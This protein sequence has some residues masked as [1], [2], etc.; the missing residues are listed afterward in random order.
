M[1]LIRIS[2][3]VACLSGLASGP[4]S[5]RAAG[6]SEPNPRTHGEVN[7]ALDAVKRQGGK[8]ASPSVDGGLIAFVGRDGAGDVA[9]VWLINLGGGAPRRLLGSLP[10]DDPKANLTELT[11][12]K[13][14]NDGRTVYVQSAAW[15]TSG[16]VH[17]IDVA[18]GAHRF[19]AA[20]NSLAVV[21]N[22][23]YSGSLIVSQHMYRRSGG[24][25]EQLWLLR[26]DGR[27]RFAIPGSSADP[28][29]PSDW[30]QRNGWRAQ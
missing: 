7:G 16:A 17:A 25:F 29:D 11:G 4:A 21:R 24:S 8:D 30:L 14:S 3:L 23:L 22:G 9:A 19:I 13:F 18:T 26:P 5:A 6:Q 27:R 15:V 28:E 10:S 2:V 12:P 1:R 20:G